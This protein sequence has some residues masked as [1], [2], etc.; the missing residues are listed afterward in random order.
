MRNGINRFT[1]GLAKKVLLANV[2][3]QIASRTILSGALADQA[4]NLATLQSAPALSLWL[5]CFG[6]ALQ[7]F[8][9]TSLPT[10]TW[11]LAWA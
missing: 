9:W 2:C 10:R 5:G 4:K 6:Y 7:R 3:G 11:P 8:T 1:S